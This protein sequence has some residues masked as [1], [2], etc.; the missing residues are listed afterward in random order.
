M[1][2][3][4]FTTLSLYKLHQIYINYKNINYAFTIIF[5]KTNW[6]RDLILLL[7][8]MHINPYFI[9]ITFGALVISDQ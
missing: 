2:T 1:R 8:I 4:L 9:S 7:S 3:M 5:N 6:R